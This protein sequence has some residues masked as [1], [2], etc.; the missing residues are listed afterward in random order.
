MA[1]ISKPAEMTVHRREGLEG[2]I[3]I[4]GPASSPALL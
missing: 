3:G 2:I 4:Y 1:M